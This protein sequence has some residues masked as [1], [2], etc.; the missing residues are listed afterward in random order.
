M[1]S[2]KGGSGTVHARLGTSEDDSTTWRRS[3]DN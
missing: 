1:G 3:L 2:L